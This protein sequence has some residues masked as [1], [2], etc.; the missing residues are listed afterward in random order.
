MASLLTSEGGL[1]YEGW[2][3]KERRLNNLLEID[4]LLFNRSY[5]VYLFSIFQITGSLGTVSK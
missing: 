2:Q 3:I 5:C 1:F 4:M